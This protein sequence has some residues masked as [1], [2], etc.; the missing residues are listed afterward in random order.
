MPETRPAAEVPVDVQLVRRLVAGQFPQW[1]ALEVE[2]VESAGWDNSIFRLGPD[3]VARLPCRR[4]SARHV[5]EEHRWLPVLAPRLPLAVPV[6]VARGAPGQGYPWYWTVFR[7][8]PGRIAALAR[9]ADM[10]RTAIELARFIRALQ[11]IDCAGGSAHEFRGFSLAAHSH[12]VTAAADLLAGSLDIGPVLR[13][14]RAALAAPAGEGQPVWIHGDLHPANLLVEADELRAVIDFGL[15][16][17]G[18]PACDL[19]VAWTYL[20]ADSRDIFRAAL[21]VDDVTWSRG[22]GWALDFGLRA[23][24]YSA[25]NLV[26][27]DIGRVTIAELLADFERDS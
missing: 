18:D 19:M 11:S 27:R 4:V 3:L 21:N 26:L 12:N 2:L 14:W 8:L 24:A 6:P 16:G 9:V 20:S 22:R 13:I 25:D 15:L 1:A 17:I 5:Q 23:T 10:N 7:W